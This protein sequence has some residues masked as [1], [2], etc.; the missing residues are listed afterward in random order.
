MQI[1]QS[2]TQPET[3]SHVRLSEP[4]RTTLS[5]L[6]VKQRIRRPRALDARTRR[7][8]SHQ[9]DEREVPKGRDRPS[10]LFQSAPRSVLL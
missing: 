5:H 8:L 7:M 10:R 2:T 3:S 1:R 4:A 9:M 6:I